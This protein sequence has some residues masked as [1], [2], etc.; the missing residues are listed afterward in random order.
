MEQE[1]YNFNM[2]WTA[3]GKDV[4]SQEMEQAKTSSELKIKEAIKLF[5][6]NLRNLIRHHRS[7]QT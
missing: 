4:I 5:A 1:E 7:S 3:G 2:D 6:S